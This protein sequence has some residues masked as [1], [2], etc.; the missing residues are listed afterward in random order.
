MNSVHFYSLDPL[1]L[2]LND[3]VNW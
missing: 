2:E 3:Y 1:V